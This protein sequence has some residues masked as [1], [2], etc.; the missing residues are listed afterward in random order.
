MNQHSA[1]QRPTSNIRAEEAVIGKIIG[2]AE[3]Y[4]A[5]AGM[6]KAEHFVVP[7]HRDIFNAVAKC[8][9]TG[10]GPTLSLLES[11]LPTGWE[12]VGDVEAV[13]QILMEKAADVGSV[14]DFVEDILVAWRERESIAIAKLANQPGKSFE[15]RRAAIEERYKAV[16]DADRAKHAVRIGEAAGR[17]LHR[18]AEA[19][20]H[21]GKRVVG[22]YTGVKE[23]DDAIGP[24]VGGTVVTIAAE[25]GHG[26]SG[27]LAQIFRNNAMPSLDLS[28]LNPSFFLSMEMSE[29][30]NAYRNQAA[31]TGISVRKQ[32]L[33]DFTEAEFHELARSKAKLDDMPIYIQDRGAMTIFEAAKEFRAAKRRHDIKIIGIDH[34]KLFEPPD[35]NMG[36]VQIVEHA[37]KHTKALAKELDCVIFQLAQITKEGQK[38]GNWRFKRGDIYGGGLLVE[39]SDIIIG[40]TVPIEWLRQNQPEPPSEAKPQNRPIFDD[41]LKNMEVWKDK[42]EIAA[43]KMRDGAS[44]SWKPLDFSG[45]RM[46]F[47]DAQRDEIPF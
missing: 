22:I 47:G 21:R 28:R 26:K 33:G 41:W 23:I 27:L 39:N 25:S 10:S 7:H 40:V 4:W 36:L 16:D 38:S 29:M 37:S 11:K 42:A 12:N 30:Q 19:Y 14:T 17:A 18:S 31:M 9:D 5:I 15:E 35:R 6:L 8:C 1:P 2:S 20:E 45:V 32:I 34:L 43:L 3:S 44:G 13:L 24:L 46:S